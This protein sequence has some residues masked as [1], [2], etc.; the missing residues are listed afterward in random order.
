M[1]VAKQLSQWQQAFKLKPNLTNRDLLALEMA[2]ANM[3]YVSAPSTGRALAY[4]TAAIETGWIVE[5][6]TVHN[7]VTD[8]ATS[9]TSSQHLFDS[10]DVLDKLNPGKTLWY[11]EQVRAAYQRATEI[12]PN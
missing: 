12:D 10:E 3:R 9:Q 11:G 2:L 8:A 5:P 4:L 1:A 7:R 6:K